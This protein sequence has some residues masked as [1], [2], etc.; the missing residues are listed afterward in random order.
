[1]RF[2]IAQI[3]PAPAAQ[4]QLLLPVIENL[5]DVNQS[6]SLTEDDFWTAICLPCKTFRL[7]YLIL[8]RAVYVY[9][10]DNCSDER[11]RPAQ[12]SVYNTLKD[13][14]QGPS[15]NLAHLWDTK[16]KCIDFIKNRLSAKGNVEHSYTDARFL[17]PNGL[18][19]QG[20]NKRQ[21][22]ASFERKSTAEKALLGF[23]E[24]ERLYQLFESSPGAQEQEKANF[25]SDTVVPEEQRQTYAMY[26]EAV[27]P[28]FLHLPRLIRYCSDNGIIGSGLTQK[29]LVFRLEWNQ[30][31][32]SWALA[33]ENGVATEE[34][35]NAN[36]DLLK[37]AGFQLGSKGGSLYSIKAPR[38]RSGKRS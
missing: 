10:V 11:I 8:Y 17:S 14:W 7:D 2:E 4:N 5:E 25:F 28:N 13:A 38:E 24:R 26:L 30:N 1:V 3:P 22:S 31:R 35:R 12:V 20:G 29:L 9:I 16:T 32:R 6:A 34:Q 27:E 19:A 15:G 18:W 37:N 23:G 33:Q 21:K 36:V